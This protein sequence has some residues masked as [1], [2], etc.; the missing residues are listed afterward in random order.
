MYLK[1]LFYW[2]NDSALYNLERLLDGLI[3]VVLNGVKYVL[4]ASCNQ[5]WVLLWICQRR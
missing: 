5:G 2:K 3:P 4:F 1:V